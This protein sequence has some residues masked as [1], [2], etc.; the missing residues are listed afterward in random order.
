MTIDVVLV[1]PEIIKW[2]HEAFLPSGMTNADFCKKRSHEYIIR[3]RLGNVSATGH[4]YIL[5]SYL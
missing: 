2:R 4:H 1:G 3:W 5:Y